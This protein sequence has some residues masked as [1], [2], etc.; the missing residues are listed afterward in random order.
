MTVIA[1]HTAFVQYAQRKGGLS[2][3][4]HSLCGVGDFR[5]GGGRR[6]ELGVARSSPRT[7][8][9]TGG[10]LHFDRFDSRSKRKTHRT[11]SGMRRFLEQ[12]TGVEPAFTAWEATGYFRYI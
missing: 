7:Q 5:T 3:T 12:D 10:L 11:P 9:A 1:D 6:I 4:L 2:K 8:P